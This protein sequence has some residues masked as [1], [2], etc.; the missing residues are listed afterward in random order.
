MTEQQSSD[1]VEIFV[2]REGTEDVILGEVLSQT[3][4]GE[5]GRR[6]LGEDAL[7]WMEDNSEPF[8]P[9]SVLVEIGVRARAHV[10]VGRCHNVD[11]TVRYVGDGKMEDFSPSVTIE[12]VFAWATGKDGFDL[13]RDQQV[14]HAL[15]VCGST[16]EPHRGTHI[17]SLATACQLCL[18]LGPK[19][20]F[21]G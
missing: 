7:V 1:I 15:V 8:A 18:E 13:T 10:Y 12:S 4:A 2:H 21:Q 20:R 11:V 16:N 17:G 3:R 5:V 9:D 14:K 19:E 6:H